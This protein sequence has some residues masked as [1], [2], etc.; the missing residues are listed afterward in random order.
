M[1]FGLVKYVY[2]EVIV[3]YRIREISDL[4]GI[5]VFLNFRFHASNDYSF[6]G[7]FQL[8]S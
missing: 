5:E 2:K 7:V 8:H 3:F 6:F 1:F 4:D